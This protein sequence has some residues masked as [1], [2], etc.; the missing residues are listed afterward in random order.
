MLDIYSLYVRQGDT[1]VIR[2]PGGSCIVIDAVR[3]DKIVDLLRSEW[4]PNGP[5]I[6]LLVITH[7]HRDHYS[8]A[9]RLLNDFTVEKVILAPFWFE[10]GTPQYHTIINRIHDDDI[11]V[12]FLSGYERIYVD[13][14][15]N[16]YPDY[17]GEVC[18]ELLGPPNHALEDLDEAN[19]INPNHL[20]I[21]SRLTYGSFRMVLAADAQMENWA[22]FDREGMLEG[23]CNV[24]KAA[25]HGSKRGTQWERLE[26]LA[27][28]LVIVSS[29][30]DGQHHLPDLIGAVTFMEF[31]DQNN[32][33][34]AL[35]QATGSL[36][37]RV[38]PNGTYTVGAYHDDVDDLLS[39]LALQV[40]P[41]TGWDALV[42][43]RMT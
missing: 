5:D 42:Q 36:R 13:A 41:Q 6:S 43:T 34:A 32:R 33:D 31:D 14:G 16:S 3:P 18:L 11:P 7:P 10:P 40:V 38:Q 26:R 15:P 30:P 37:I 24:L 35:T 27:P 29:D 1:T 4:P 12:Q 21:I 22:H 25:H 23:G 8:G 20:S 9:N 28:E 2:T 39:G 17:A 19:Q